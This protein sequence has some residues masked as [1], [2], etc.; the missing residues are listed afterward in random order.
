MDV[1]SYLLFVFT[2]IIFIRTR[3]DHVEKTMETKS[4]KYYRSKLKR[5]NQKKK[6]EKR[7]EKK[8]NKEILPFF[9]L[10]ELCRH[11]TL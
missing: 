8:L 11:R 7:I 1:I 3:K 5:T 6:S 9:P 4:E 2:L 10:L